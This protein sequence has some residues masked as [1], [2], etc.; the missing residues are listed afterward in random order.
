MSRI[1]TKLSGLAA[2]AAASAAMCLASTANASTLTLISATMNQ[3]YTAQITGPLAPFTG[4]GLDVYE[5]PITF[6]VSDATHAH[7][8]TIT[9]FCVDLFDDIGLGAFSPN[10]SYETETLTTTRDVDGQ[11]LGTPLSGLQLTEINR[12]LTLAYTFEATPVTYAS[13]LAAIQG[14]I[15][16]VE[17]PLYTVASHNGLNALTNTYIAD[18]A[19]T[20]PAT[21]GFLPTGIETTIITTRTA[22]GNYHQSFAFAVPS[23][24]P[25]PATWGLMIMGF[26]GVGAMLRRRRTATAFA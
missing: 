6:T 16:E 12:L 4:G 21:P 10:L 8:Y 26:G 14:A 3:S 25:E 13:N 24:A 18:A 23:G 19:I 15:W 2:V 17:N 9:A 1:G 20:N 11:H 7:P 5:G 22:Q